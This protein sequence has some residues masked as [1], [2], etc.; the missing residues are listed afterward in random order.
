MMHWQSWLQ[1]RVLGRVLKNSSYLFASY[2][3]GAVLTILTARLLGVAS[4]GVLGTVTVV[5][6]N[7]NRLFSF[8]MGDVVVKYVGEALER[9][10]PRRAAAVV[11]ASF[12]V[13]ALT[14]LLAFVVLLVLAPLGARYLA[15][16]SQTAGLFLL[17]GVSILTSA[18]SEAAT[19]VLQVTDHYRSQALI[20]LIQTV[21]V[22]VL[23]GLAS[24]YQWD[25]WPV[26]A[27]YL[28]GKAILG[29]GPLLVALFWLPRA[30]GADWLRAPFSALPPRREMLRFA[31]NTNLHGT[32]TMVARDSEVPVVSFF[33]GPAAA[34]YYK[35]ALA[36][37]NMIVQP[38]N[39][40]IATTY[41]AITRAFTGGHWQRLKTLLA[42]VTVLSAAWTAAVAL[43]LALFGRQILFQPWQ[44]FGVRVDLLS[45]YEPALGLVFLL[46]IGYGAANILFWN[47]PLLLAQGNAAFPFR[48][49]FWA[50]LAKVLL[51]VLLLPGGQIWMAAALLSGYLLV[52]VLVM[53][54]R[55]VRGVERARLEA[56]NVPE[57]GAA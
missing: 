41:P 47:R 10:E 22:A 48:V 36:L 11:K 28:L 30:L 19:G 33:F 38:I 51:T 37:I 1:D 56:Q 35:I 9:G 45:E 52:T 21:I 43:G 31:L 50:M 42:R 17:Y 53:A 26:M 40:L 34:G 32:V 46:L 12:L 6:A 15:K 55:G 8:R 20:N 14:S 23:L 2:V 5:V 18:F 39:P 57:A 49:S 24:I 54:V 25:I 13:E 44:L 3:I 27:I 16:D 4:F 29:L 7:I